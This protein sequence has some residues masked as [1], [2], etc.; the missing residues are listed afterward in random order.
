MIQKSN[1]FL[2]QMHKE[3]HSKNKIQPIIM[4]GG[5]GKR[6]WPIS[7]A[8]IP[9]Q[10]H[11]FNQNF[12]LLQNTIIR[13]AS[14]G[15]PIIIINAQ[16]KEIAL[17]QINEIGAECEIIIEANNFGTASCSIFAAMASKEAGADCCLLIP[18]DHLI[19][20]TSNYIKATNKA[21][22]FTQ[23][24]QIVTIGIQPTYPNEEYGYI[25]CGQKLEKDVYECDRFVEK[26]SKNIATDYFYDQSFLWNSGIFLYCPD[27]FLSMAAKFEQQMLENSQKIWHNRS[28]SANCTYLQNNLD[29]MQKLDIEYAFVEKAKNIKVVRGDFEFNDFGNFINLFESILE[30]DANNNYLSS[31]SIAST[32]AKNCYMMHDKKMAIIIGLENIVVVSD[33]ENLLIASKE[34]V[35]EIKNIINNLK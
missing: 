30:K 25:K 33:N 16:Q 35:H 1:L 11:K 17:K 3:P 8:R 12:S 9:K 18:A 19:N 27:T 6:L 22:S 26:P 7:S 29:S 4:A 20:D 34:K 13:I 32:D 10:F 31:N 23:Q 15:K 21:A 2:G 14:F 28:I 24:S 5:T